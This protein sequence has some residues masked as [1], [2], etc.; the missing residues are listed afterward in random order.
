MDCICGYQLGTN[1]N[2]S[3]CKEYAEMKTLKEAIE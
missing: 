2:C 1:P 3:Y